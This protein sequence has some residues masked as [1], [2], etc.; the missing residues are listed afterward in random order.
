MTN[1]IRDLGD[2]LYLKQSTL[3]DIE[4][5]ADYNARQLS[6]EG[7]DQPEEVL[8][9]WTKDL[10][11]RHPTAGPDDFTYVEE[12]QTGK[13]VSSL[14]LISQNWVYE[15]IP[16]G[17]GRVEMVSTHREYR[18]KGLVRAQFDV[19]HQWS[20]ERGHKMQAITGIPYFYRQ[21]GYEMT[22]SLGGARRGYRPHIP[23]LKD[24]ETEPYQIRSAAPED[25]PFI[26]EMYDRGRAL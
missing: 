9:H 14:C 26:G 3:D 24:D 11:T 21:F 12:A 17:V 4:R 5:L 2:G 1:I 18:R 10:M 6:D 25:I 13:I 8:R 16:F 19:F 23:K 15:D 7:P 22:L 20:N